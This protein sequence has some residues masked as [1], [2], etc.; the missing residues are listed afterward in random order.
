MR[1]VAAELGVTPMALY[2]LVPDA[3]ALSRTIADSAAAP[4]RPKLTGAPLTDALAR[5]A[6]LAYRHLGHYPGLA[7]FVMMEW[8]ELP[9]WL[10]V[11]EVLLTEAEEQGIAGEHGVATV[12]AVFAFVLTRAQL[13]DAAAVAPRRRLRPVAENPDRYPL[14]RASL[15]EYTTAQTAKHFEMGLTTLIAGL[16]SPASRT[17][18]P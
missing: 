3:V 11:V 9:S 6:T 1:S 15:A 14:I 8:T 16:R 10:D 4:I 13:R 17:D 12:N 7:A 5:W 2:R 18:G